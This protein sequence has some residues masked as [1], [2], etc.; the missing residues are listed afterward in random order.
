MPEYV[1]YHGTD[2]E[3]AKKI[4]EQQKFLPS[5]N[6]WLG[7]GIY[8]FPYVA[9]AVW[10]CEENKKLMKGQY[11]ILKVRL[12]TDKVL[13]LLGSGETIKDFRKICDKIKNKC[14]NS[15][16]S[17]CQKVE[18]FM[19]LAINAFL[20]VSREVFNQNF[21]VIVAG[22][23]QNRKDWYF[24]KRYAEEKGK[25]PI[26]VAQIQYCVRNSKCITEIANYE[27]VS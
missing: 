2:N 11:K 12:M 1:G 27:E 22:F 5:K 3:A 6:G 10:W 15:H 26:V 4:I 14:V 20:K 8:V 25:F 21:D 17:Y 13:E 7:A 16:L 19:S 9:D 24:G 23:D 18:H